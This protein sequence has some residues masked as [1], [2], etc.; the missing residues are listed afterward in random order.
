MLG[1][2]GRERGVAGSGFGLLVERP[3]ADG[4]QAFG[5]GQALAERREAAQPRPRKSGPAR[6]P[7]G[8]RFDSRSGDAWHRRQCKQRL[9][10]R[11]CQ[12]LVLAG[13]SVRTATRSSG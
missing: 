4:K 7:I 8:E 1:S 13:H 12:G 9:T 10:S 6:A 2:R 5:L 3:L 11:R